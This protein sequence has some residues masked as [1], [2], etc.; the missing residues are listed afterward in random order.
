[1]PFWVFFLVAETYYN[2]IC[3]QG[4]ICIDLYTLWNRL[5]LY[6]TDEEIQQCLLITVDIS[7]SSLSAQNPKTSTV[8]AY[9]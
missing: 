9:G 1:M 6:K 7:M 3:H 2:V 4:L 5:M 8:S